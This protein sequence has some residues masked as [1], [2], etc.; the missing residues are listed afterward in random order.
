MSDII[1]IEPFL[2]GKTFIIPVYQRD[3]AWTTTQVDDLLEDISEAIETSSPHYL[4]TVVLAHG[5]SGFEIVDGQQRLSTLTLLIHALLEELPADDQ[6]RIIDTGILLKR[7]GKLKLDFGKNASFVSDLFSGSNRLPATA[8]QRKLLDAYK[9]ACEW[10]KTLSNTGGRDLIVKWMGTI[11]NLEVIQFDAKDT[12]RAIRM[13][14]T[15]ND[16]GLPLSAMDKAKALLVF[17]S[18]RRLDGDLDSSISSYFGKCFAAFDE[19]RE[20]VRLPEFRI[21]NIAR[22][23]FSEDDLLRYHYLSYSFPDIVG[24]ATITALSRRC[25]TAS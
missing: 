13:F 1:K 2:V 14:Q 3:Y 6:E 23:T 9:H 21:D 19:M 12:G 5:E 8:G 20:F 16:R 24:A 4:G 11:K 10:A 22:D 25:S 17:Y 7:A 15:I 18:N